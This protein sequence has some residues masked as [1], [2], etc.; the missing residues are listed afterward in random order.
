MC[1][2]VGVLLCC[3]LDVMLCCCVAVL[4]CWSSVG[5]SF[6]FSH[7]L[8]AEHERFVSIDFRSESSHD[9]CELQ[10]RACMM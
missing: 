4:L 7:R 10:G 1:W 5:H 6:V 8:Y 2:S 9:A 3:V